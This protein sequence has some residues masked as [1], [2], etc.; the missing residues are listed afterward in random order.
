[1][2]FLASDSTTQP[3]CHRCAL[4]HNTQAVITNKTKYR[5]AKYER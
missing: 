3:Y 4:E 5:T 2:G 1:M